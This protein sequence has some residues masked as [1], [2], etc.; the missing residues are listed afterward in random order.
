MN[1]ARDFVAQDGYLRP[2]LA[3]VFS[4]LLLLMVF[5]G[6]RWYFGENT[7]QQLFFKLFIPGHLPDEIRITPEDKRALQTF[8]SMRNYDEDLVAELGNCKDMLDASE[9]L[10]PVRFGHSYLRLSWFF[11][12]ILLF[13]YLWLLCWLLAEG[14][15]AESVCETGCSSFLARLEAQGFDCYREDG[16]YIDHNCS[17]YNSVMRCYRARHFVDDT[18]ILRNLALGAAVLPPYVF[19]FVRVPAYVQKTR[20]ELGTRFERR[21][22]VGIAAVFSGSLC[23]YF[24]TLEEVFGIPTLSELQHCHH[25]PLLDIVFM[26]FF[27][28]FASGLGL[29]IGTANNIVD[30]TALRRAI[31]LANGTHSATFDEFEGFLAQRKEDQEDSAS[32]ND[33]LACLSEEVTQLNRQ[34]NEQLFWRCLYK[35]SLFLAVGLTI[36]LAFYVHIA[37]VMSAFISWLLPMWCCRKANGEEVNWEIK[38]WALAAELCGDLSKNPCIA[39]VSLRRAADRRLWVEALMSLGYTT[40]SDLRF[41]GWLKSSR[42]VPVP[43]VWNTR[44]GEYEAW[45]TLCQNHFSLG[46]EPTNEHVLFAPESFVLWAKAAE[47]STLVVVDEP[48][49]LRYLDQASQK[50][51]KSLLDSCICK[52]L[53]SE[54]DSRDQ[55]V[56]WW[57]MEQM[58][59]LCLWED[60][61]SDTESVGTDDAESVVWMHLEKSNVLYELC[62]SWLIHI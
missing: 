59:A 6:L 50:S 53:C 42:L 5:V 2:T 30:T 14:V 52:R 33:A 21:V 7:L 16:S 4:A 57:Q 61:Q 31:D 29:A 39:T 1:D 17:R 22:W 49:T 36:S 34:R 41:R 32:N 45:R 28:C 56:C 12:V 26:I 20:V 9:R 43:E 46:P 19:F 3:A 40:R 51:Q 8:A 55:R 23:L 54:C 62:A 18:L 13:Y 47:K 48:R 27:W 24:V 60:R 38:V 37:T 25:V 11:D 44:Y 15:F 10:D 35:L 58:F